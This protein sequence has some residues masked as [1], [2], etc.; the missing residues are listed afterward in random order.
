MRYLRLALVPLVFAACTEH[1]APVPDVEAEPSFNFMNGPDNPGNVLRLEAYGYLS[2]TDPVEGLRVRFYDTF[3]TWRCGGSTDDPIWVYQDT[4]EGE[5]GATVQEVGTS[6]EVPFVVYPHPNTTGKP[7]CQF[8]QEDWL[9]RGSGTV[10]VND[11]NYFW[12]TGTSG[13][14]AVT[15]RAN[16]T[17]EDAAGNTHNLTAFTHYVAT[18]LC[19]FFGYDNGEPFYIAPEDEDWTEV[20]YKTWIKITP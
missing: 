11:S 13:T 19:C 2:I 7:F 4:Q 12:F 18:G 17:V 3:D 5:F 20:L 14:D 6:Q 10:R 1:Q 15:I 9:Y 8:L 16:G